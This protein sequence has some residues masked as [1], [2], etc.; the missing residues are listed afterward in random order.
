[1]W[2]SEFWLLVGILIVVS[3]LFTE[4]I[5]LVVKYAQESLCAI[6][7]AG[8]QAMLDSR[9]AEQLASLGISDDCNWLKLLQSFDS[10]GKGGPMALS[11]DRNSL[12]QIIAAR[13]LDEQMVG[14]ASFTFDELEETKLKTAVIL[15]VDGPSQKVYARVT[16]QEEMREEML[17]LKEKI[18]RG[19]TT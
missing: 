19:A 6:R 10:H 9:N 5:C 16:V 2:S 12:M 13:L 11:F 4:E 1:M 8:R 14:D 7:D 3:A 18:Q 15:V 17:R